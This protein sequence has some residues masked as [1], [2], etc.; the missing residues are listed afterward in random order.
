MF[1][2]VIF[3]LINII[4][5]LNS[6]VPRFNKFN[7][8]SYSNCR[9]PFK[10]SS[11]QKNEKELDRPYTLPPGEFRPKQSLGQNFLSDQNYVNKIVDALSD[12]STVI[13]L[14]I[15]LCKKD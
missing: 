1:V 9:L 13:E 12:N 4:A 2:L 3:Y 6:M 11:T 10:L 14:Y 5:S 8:R 7:I 15:Y